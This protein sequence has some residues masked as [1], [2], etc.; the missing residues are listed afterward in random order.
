[1]GLGHSQ[2]SP[3]FVNHEKDEDKLYEN[4][5][6]KFNVESEIAKKKINLFKRFLKQPALRLRYL[7]LSESFIN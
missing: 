1:M 2:A 3:I 6:Q 4:F 5:H 7:L